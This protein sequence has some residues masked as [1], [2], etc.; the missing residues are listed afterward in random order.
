MKSVFERPSFAELLKCGANV[1]LAALRH[2]DVG[3]VC[4]NRLLCYCVSLASGESCRLRSAL[5]SLFY[6]VHCTALRQ[7]ASKGE[8][9]EGVGKSHC[10]VVFA[11]ETPTAANFASLVEL[12]TY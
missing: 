1:P 3:F 2:C 11:V 8:A 10:D 7:R 12:V 9:L 4:T 6:L 5:F